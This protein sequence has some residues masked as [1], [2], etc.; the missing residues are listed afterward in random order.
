MIDQ[1][2]KYFD[3]VLFD[4]VTLTALAATG[5]SVASA[6]GTVAGAAAPATLAL[7]AGASAVGTAVSAA[8]QINAGKAAQESAQFTAAQLRSNA[9]QSIASAQR[10]AI[11]T[12]TKGRLL[13]S[14]TTAAAGA[15]G[16]NAGVGSPAED[17]ADI[18]ARTKYNAA[19]DL[20]RG[21][22]TATGL[23]NQAVADLWS[24]DAA[25]K[26]AQLSAFGT[27]AAGAGS[28][29]GQYGRYLPGVPNGPR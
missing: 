16:V 3:T 26:G 29:A 11:D 12:Q 5:A 28:I 27:I 21:Q 20:F 24:G 23:E 19:L 25:R 18:T 4:P 22:S 14:K 1:W 13:A 7:G 10:S 9:G 15:S 8:G 17:I 2:R 6:A